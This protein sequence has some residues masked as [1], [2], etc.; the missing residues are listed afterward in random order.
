MEVN[1]FGRL[2]NLNLPIAKSLL[3]IIEAIVNSIQATEKGKNNQIS[4]MINHDA[5]HNVIEEDS[6]S[7]G[8]ITSFIIEDEGAGFNKENYDSFC[9]S[10]SIFKED[11]GGKGIGR[12]LWLKAFDEVQVESI[13]IDSG[14]Y[15]RRTFSFSARKNG[16]SNHSLNKIQKQRIHTQVKLLGLNSQY[17]KYIS[18]SKATI[19]QRILEYILPFYLSNEIPSITIGDSTSKFSL[20]SIFEHE[21]EKEIERKE[22]RINETNFVIHFVKFYSSR[23]V[24]HK[25]SLCAHFREVRKINLNE[26]FPILTTRITEGDKE[27]NL[28]AYVSSD[29]LDST[30][31][32]E[33][34][35]FNI[36]KDG[37]EGLF[38]PNISFNQI[39]KEATKY[40]TEFLSPIIQPLREANLQRIEKFIQEKCPDFRHIINYSKEELQDINPAL[41]GEHL[42]LEIFRISQKVERKIKEKAIVVLDKVKTSPENISDYIS[43]MEDALEEVSEMSRSKLARYILYRKTILDLFEKTLHARSDGKYELESIVHNMIYPVRTTSDEVMNSKQNLWL[44]DEKLC[45]H[46]LLASDKSLATVDS[47]GKKSLSRPDIIVYNNPYAFAEDTSPHSS[48]VIIE[49][50]RPMRDDYDSEDNPISQVY[51]YIREIRNGNKTDLNGRPFPV[52][53]NTPFYSYI[54]SDITKSLIKQ[55]ENSHFTQTPD[56]QGYFGFNQN[57]KCY[58]EIISFDKLLDDA[59]KRNKFLFEKLG[60][61]TH[62]TNSI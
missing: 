15:Y 24:N 32:T 18:K 16:V 7:L 50:K 54:I 42:E 25:L 19:A 47:N 56:S 9:T 62:S 22:F 37:A 23:D 58:T 46:Y 30:V 44:I 28:F 3:P 55:A 13:F 27:Y 31:N 12:F 1:V 26:K 39:V 35:A 40:I 41:S 51:D 36:E 20:N 21:Y 38:E 34:T 48:I 10:D 57:L 14:E 49:F 52:N 29:Y 33:R 11:L 6:D 17:R 53:E 8:E 2:K 43:E 5:F 59:R 61:P 4:L 60:L 45:Y